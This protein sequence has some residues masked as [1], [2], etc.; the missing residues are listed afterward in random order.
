MKENEVK[1]NQGGTK[2]VTLGIG[3]SNTGDGQVSDLS[4][5]MGIQS[6]QKV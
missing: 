2:L 3:I 1:E 5:T 4:L 6:K